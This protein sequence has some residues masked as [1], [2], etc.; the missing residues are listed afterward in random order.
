MFVESFATSEPST[1]AAEAF[2]R[3]QRCHQ[4]TAGKHTPE[5][6]VRDYDRGEIGVGTEFIGEQNRVDRVRNAELS[7]VT[8]AAS[9]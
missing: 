3:T 5:R 4:A 9:P 7:V 1:G 6:L 2:A 8:T